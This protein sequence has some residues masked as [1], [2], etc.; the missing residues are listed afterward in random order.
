MSRIQHSIGRLLAAIFIT[1][2]IST[3][4]INTC[5]AAELT[6]GTAKNEITPAIGTP[7]SGYGKIRGK[8]SVGMHDPL[9]ARSL[10]LSYG[11]QKIVFVSLDLCL[12]D[13]KLRKTI[14]QK[15]NA[16]VL[17][18]S[19]DLLL[20]AT[21]THTGSGAIGGRHWEK[22]I[23]GKFRKSVFE[24]LTDQ[25]ARTI[26]ESIQNPIPVRAEYGS[27]RIDDLVENRMDKKLT[28]PK[29]LKLMR[30][31]KTD[32]SLAGQILFMAAH[33]TL[34]PWRELSFSADY[35]GVVTSRLEE[36]HTG[37]VTV[38]INGAAG[39]L[40]PHTQAAEDRW[41]SMENY[42]KAIVAKVAQVSYAPLNLNG[43]W[44]TEIQR[45]RLPRTRIRLGWF[46]IPS[47]LGNRIFP[48]KTYFQAIRMGDFVVVT[49]P[50]ELAS[51][52]GYA[53]ERQIRSSALKPFIAGYANDYVGY[54]VS[55]H[56]YHKGAGQYESRVSFYGGKLSDFY[57]ER[58]AKL[59]AAVKTPEE[60]IEKPADLY[61]HQ[62]LPVLKL[63]GTAYH[64]GYEEGR[65]LRDE[66]RTG[67]SAIF[68]YFR[69]ELHLPLLNRLIINHIG[70]RAW[71]KMA[72][73]VSY[74]EKQQ[75]KG[76]AD[77]SGVS[78]KVLQRI[79][80]M[81]ELYPTFCSNGAYW[82]PATSSGQLIAIRNL[83]WNR[84]MGV[85]EWAVVKYVEN[86]AGPNYVNIGYYGFTGVL[87]GMNA[88]GL[89]VGQIGATSVDET[90]E[91][92]PMPFLLKRVL[93]EAESL[94][95]AIGI[96]ERNYRTRGYNYLIA[97]AVRKE[98]VAVETT[99]NH[100]AVFRDH[101]PHELTV[102][103]ALPVHS[104][105]FRGDP[106]LDPVIRNLQRA[107]KGDPD[108]PGLEVPRGSAY[109]IRYLKH[110]NLVQDHF[111]KIDAEVAQAIALEI[112]P[113]SNIQSVVYA[114]P[115]F[116]VANAKDGKRAA[117]TEYLR[118]N[119]DELGRDAA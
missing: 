25:V 51:D 61:Y 106:A 77:G 28:H 32:G 68:K 15:V 97:D 107:S 8:P 87:S 91:G 41:R 52:V 54:A 47:I 98:A 24:K 119:F 9:Y 13:E 110:G 50:G 60:R 57:H 89:S 48:R 76:M 117:E 111:G 92:V 118:F 104:A 86:G 6:L 59:L 2:S 101:D 69:S 21:H 12:I 46:R 31:K 39:D 74:E 4:Y 99:Q 100:L 18:R 42:G 70:D 5:R 23:M 88:R 72:P 38:F 62:D 108:T 43:V 85:H 84:H 103:Y 109:E 27:V 53:L 82:G 16:G 26:I 102:N 73:Y 115:D 105:V 113:Q 44:K 19:E 78:L 20:T 58:V 67:S 45:V 116:W 81:P 34:A 95:D 93:A 65:L 33:A 11:D 114:F 63:G 40:R 17:L 56:Q 71:K 14:L 49:F 83:D 37:S 90:M 79:H 30:F 35:P 75:L 64:R 36:M 22:Y 7:L 94:E 55:P 112:A 3:C 10:A 80:A 1:L 96:L 29:H 66:I